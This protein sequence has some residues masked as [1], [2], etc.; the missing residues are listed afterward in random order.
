M[1]LHLDEFYSIILDLHNIEVSI[2]V[3][4]LVILF[5]S[6]SPSYKNFRVTLLYGINTLCSEDVKKVLA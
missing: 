2:K 3:E 6:L 1:K 4:D 5:Y